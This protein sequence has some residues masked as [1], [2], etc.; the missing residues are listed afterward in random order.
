[1]EWDSMQE[2]HNDMY[3]QY[4][5]LRATNNKIT[6][7]VRGAIANKHT[8]LFK[9]REAN[10]RLVNGIVGTDYT[11]GVPADVYHS[12]QLAKEFNQPHAN[13]RRKLKALVTSGNFGNTSKATITSGV[14]RNTKTEVEVLTKKQYDTLHMAMTISSSILKPS[15]VYLIQGAGL[16]KIGISSNVISRFKKLTTSSPVPITLLYQV[17]TTTAR[18]VEKRLHAKYA[19]H[20]SHGEWFKLDQDQ[21]KEITAYLDNL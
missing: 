4:R 9:G 18:T 8:L 14:S 1:M 16:T 3:I 10:S 6:H 20:I 2:F 7:T 15:N 5:D 17:A 21:I 19:E 11:K 13:V 12:I